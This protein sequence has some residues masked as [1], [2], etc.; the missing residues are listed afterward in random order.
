MMM[1]VSRVVSCSVNVFFNFFTS[2]GTPVCNVNSTLRWRCAKCVTRRLSVTG[3]R[4]LLFTKCRRRVQKKHINKPWIRKLLQSSGQ[5]RALAPGDDRGRALSKN[6]ENDR[7]GN[8][9]DVI[10]LIHGGLITLHQRVC[11]KALYV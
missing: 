9:R 8:C 3:W 10:S 1:M 7:E 11:L 6:I 5:S 2:Y 4:H